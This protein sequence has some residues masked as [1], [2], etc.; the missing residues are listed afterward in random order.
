MVAL[1]TETIDPLTDERWQRFVESAQGAT[2]FHHRDWLALLHEQYGYSM[3]AHCVSAAGE[4]VAGLPLARVR[5]A[6]TGR[7]LVAIPFSDA[8]GPLLL[9]PDNDAL[10]DLLLREIR[11][12]HLRGGV[13]IEIRAALP[14]L[15][16]PGE[17]FYAHEVPLA[18]GAQAV[19]ERFSKMTVRGVARARR[20]GVQ[21]LAARDLGA[22]GDFYRLHLETRRRQG[23]PT[24]PKRFVERFAALFERSL[25]FV[26]L[27]RHEQR[28]I[29]AAVFLCF[30][31]VLTYKYGASSRADLAHH[32]NN[33][34]FAEAI[35]WACAEG[36]HTLDL[37]RTDIDNEGLRA[38]KRGWG[39]QERVLAYTLLSSH[40][41]RPA[42]PRTRRMLRSTISHTPPLTGRMIGATLYRHFG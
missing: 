41:A 11:E 20:D 17:R 3:R 8:L 42:L 30:N 37:G 25:G 14:A 26:L 34:I 9:D 24:Q 38:F 40:A 19:R 33:A 13:D 36:M 15:G 23:M 22:L 12:T 32:P 10:L 39:A 7:R 6:L 35:D 18:G 16:R 5:S 31:G 29:A 21:V 4:I 28:T 27:A 2:I 1:R